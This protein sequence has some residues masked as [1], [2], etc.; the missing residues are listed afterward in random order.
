[1]PATIVPQNIQQQLEQRLGFHALLTVRVAD[2]EA[3]RPLLAERALGAGDGP[4]RVVDVG[5]FGGHAVE[6]DHRE[7]LATHQAR[8]IRVAD[9][10][11]AEVEAVSKRWRNG[12]LFC[13]S[14]GYLMSGYTKHEL[15][16]TAQFASF[17]PPKPTLPDSVGHHKE[18]IEACRTRAPTSCGFDYA[19]PLTETVLLANVSHRLGGKQLTWDAKTATVTNSPKAAKLLTKEYRAGFGPK[20]W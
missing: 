6:L 4:V 9:V 2:R 8:L 10:D 7:V 11:A 19:G 15:L 3:Q 5:R 14:K 17:E 1:M 16:P 20:D 13:G 18:W 12:V